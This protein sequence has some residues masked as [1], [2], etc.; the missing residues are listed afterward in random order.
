MSS[1][2]DGKQWGP[3]VSHFRPVRDWDALGKSGA[4][5]FA[6]KATE[7]LQ[8]VDPT[9]AAHRA[10]IRERPEFSTVVY[11]HF[12]RCEKSPQDQA[13]FFART[14]GPLQP[15]ERLCLDF[16]DKSYEALDVD[17]VCHH[18]LEY[19][20]AFFARLE[21]IGATYGSRPL[22]Y[23]SA[24]HWDAIDRPAWSRAS[25]LDLWVPRYCDPPKEPA[26]LPAPWSSWSIFQWTDG[27]DGVHFNV[28]GIG[29]CDVS[30][31]AGPNMCTEAHP[32]N[33]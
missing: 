12:L 30:V 22:I 26:R 18:G 23:T 29:L 24:R 7:G 13:D 11:Y 19:L 17:V 2:V 15:R 6:A 14:V 1:Y 25:Q 8:H 31:L 16:E 32:E 5:F 33:G 21:Q 27:K 3:D 10:G 28:P 9:F 20:E 4:T